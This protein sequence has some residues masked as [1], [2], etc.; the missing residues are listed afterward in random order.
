MPER[1]NP[2][3]AGSPEE[4]PSP[5]PSHTPGPQGHAPIQSALARKL[6]QRANAGDSAARSQLLSATR[7][8]LAPHF[9]R[10]AAHVAAHGS[11]R[12]AD[13]KRFPTTSQALRELLDA[14]LGDAIATWDYESEWL[15]HA[16]ITAIA[17]MW[18]AVAPAFR[19]EAERI[20]LDAIRPPRFPRSIGPALT[21]SVSCLV[22][23]VCTEAP[24][25]WL[26]HSLELPNWAVFV[27]SWA[28][29]HLDELAKEHELEGDA[30]ELDDVLLGRIRSI[31]KHLMRLRF[32][33]PVESMLDDLESA[34]KERVMRAIRFNKS[35]KP[36][37]LAFLTTTARHAISA[38]LNPGRSRNLNAM[39]WMIH[40]AILE[41][42]A[43]KIREGGTS[44]N[45]EPTV[46]EIARRLDPAYDC[47][48]RRKPAYSHARIRELILMFMLD[49]RETDAE[50]AQED[51]RPA[52]EDAIS[53]EVAPGAA[54]EHSLP[55]LD[56]LM[57]RARLTDEQRQV[58]RLQLHGWSHKQ[59]AEKLD[60]TPQRSRRL[61]HIAWKK[62]NAVAK[63]LSD[64]ELAVLEMRVIQRKTDHQIASHLRIPEAEVRILFHSA[65]EQLSR[66][67]ELHAGLTQPEWQALGLALLGMAR[68][69]IAGEMNI[70]L[71]EVAA[72]LK[73][74]IE[75]LARPAAGKRPRKK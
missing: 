57:H 2:D 45:C 55:T 73:S 1:P 51:S 68:E 13:S 10:I 70:P 24:K 75:K 62:I 6:C 29:K 25:A 32:G 46:D 17:K 15:E 27:D 34:A 28:L 22:Q 30:S 35:G 74:G 36:L 21:Q 12:N 54:S 59:I 50:V 42:R 37:S 7:A 72:L 23:G 5:P 38:A 39:C 71:H 65:S 40:S 60:I 66:F 41:I 19:D 61:L 4:P 56:N 31:A 18:A 11:L 20:I 9:G 49:S 44:E 64:Y 47:G 33:F 52:P 58:F 8:H 69:V 53:E 16:A 14:G 43:R 26:L 63:W 48:K 3:S 67:P